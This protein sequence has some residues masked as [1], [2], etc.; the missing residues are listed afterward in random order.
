MLQRLEHLPQK[1]L[2]GRVGDLPERHFSG[3]LAQDRLAKLRDFKESRHFRFLSGT[4]DARI[5]V[6]RDTCLRIRF[7]FASFARQAYGSLACGFARVSRETVK[8]ASV[9]LASGTPLRLIR[10]KESA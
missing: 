2:E 7:L 8:R 4:K 1:C 5:V 10:M 3:R 9:T 6:I